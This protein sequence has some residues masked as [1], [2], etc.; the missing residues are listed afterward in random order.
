MMDKVNLTI[1]I[2]KELRDKC[3]PILRHSDSSYSK[4]VT[5]HLREL[6]TEE[7]DK[8]KLQATKPTPTTHIKWKL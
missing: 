6:I 3:S 1:Q 4:F 5:K 8:D 2:E 7:E